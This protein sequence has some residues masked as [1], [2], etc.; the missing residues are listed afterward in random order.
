MAQILFSQPGGPRLCTIGS[1][2]MPPRR[3]PQS[4]R[5]KANSD[6]QS[7]SKDSIV[8]AKQCEGCSAL[9]KTVERPAGA[10]WSDHS[11]LGDMLVPV[12]ELCAKCNDMRLADWPYK[13]PYIKTLLKVLQALIEALRVLGPT[14]QGSERAF[15]SSKALYWPIRACY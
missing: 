11:R 2:N 13:S 10:A 9:P 12:G 3:A 14:R 1:N 6:D 15:E 8:V 4:A 7:A 5:G